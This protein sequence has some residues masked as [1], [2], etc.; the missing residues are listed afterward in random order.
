MAIVFEH[1]IDV[2]QSPNQVFSLIDDY[3]KVPLW[4]IRCEGVAKQGAGPN[5]VG[6]KL[7]YAYC[8]H[9]KH[10]LMDGVIVTQD[11]DSR[12]SYKY[13]DKM[14]QVFV[15]F[16]L[17]PDGAGTRLTHRIE[18]TPHSFMAKLMSPMYR[19]KLPKQTVAAMAA[20]KALLAKE[21]GAV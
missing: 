13:Y 18:I 1:S 16:R 4:A 9:G 11:Q 15:D 17:E 6:D 14:M 20:L 12:L 3:K 5:K 7:R 21:Y 10:G 2:P 8:E 19:M